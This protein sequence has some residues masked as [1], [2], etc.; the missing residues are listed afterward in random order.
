M[1]LCAGERFLCVRF[2][3]FLFG[4]VR[5]KWGEVKYSICRVIYIY[6]TEPID[7][8]ECRDFN[9]SPSFQVSV[10]APISHKYIEHENQFSLQ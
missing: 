8:V 2:L 3:V 1:G 5:G 4:V 9:L 6:I 10:R 7:A